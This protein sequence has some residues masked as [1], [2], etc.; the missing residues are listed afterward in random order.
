MTFGS[1]DKAS[2]IFLHSLDQV[3]ASGR[4]KMFAPHQRVNMLFDGI[5]VAS[6]TLSMTGVMNARG[7]Q[8]VN[9]RVQ[10]GRRKEI[11][12]GKYFVS[13]NVLGNL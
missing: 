13:Q 6:E 7:N 11:G 8:L 3:N 4:N 9:L 2:F 1:S 10:S 12:T 5:L